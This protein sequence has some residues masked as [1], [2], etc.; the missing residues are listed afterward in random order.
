MS[1]L[2]TAFNSLEKIFAQ[3][4]VWVVGGAVRDRTLK[5][6]TID[7]DFVLLHDPK[8][9]AEEFAQKIQGSSFRLDEEFAITRVTHPNGFQFD[10]GRIQGKSLEADLDRRDFTVNALAVPFSHWKSSQWSKFIL[11]R[12]QGLEDLKKKRLV[13]IS[14]GIFRED[15]IRLLRAFRLWGELGLTPSRETKSLIQK[16]G[17]LIFKSAP[18]RIRDEMLKLFS[19]RHSSEIVEAMNDLKFL[20]VLMPESRALKKT[21]RIYYGKD[22][23][24]RHTLD[25]LELLEEIFDSLRQWF[26]KCATKIEQYLDTSMS[27]YPRRAHMK[28]AILLHD[29]GKP[30]T[31]KFREGRLRFFEHEHAGAD[32]IPGLAKRF[33]WSVDESRLYES[34]VRNH[35]RPGNLATHSDISDK[36][37]HRFF[38]DLGEDAVGMLLVSLGDHLSYLTPRE[39][40]KRKSPHEKIAIKMMNRYFLQREKVIPSRV[41]NGHEIMKALNIKPS[42]LVGEIL[43]EITEAQS[44]GKVHTREEALA[45]AKSRLPDLQKGFESR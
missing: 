32:K 7:F 5:R 41:V 17:K 30:D 11:D 15:P 34:M 1:L 23:V 33:R 3:Q 40:K 6:D 39:R 35:M 22:G 45:L 14:P 38:R 4:P 10:F 24:L 36:A 16:N 42:P 9:I 13:A 21:G 18:E 19:V 12:H 8:K 29:L 20:D 27:G 43:K 25:S 31:A 37:I 28:W 2:R 44:E 26:P